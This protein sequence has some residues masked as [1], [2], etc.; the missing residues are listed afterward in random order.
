MAL[1]PDWRFE[2]EALTRKAALSPEL[3]AQDVESWADLGRRAYLM[4]DYRACLDLLEACVNISV[5]GSK[6]VLLCSILFGIKASKPLFQE[7]GH[8]EQVL[9]LNSKA[10]ALAVTEA[11]LNWLQEREKVA[12]DNLREF[13]SRIA[14]LPSGY[15]PPN[16]G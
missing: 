4:Q 13:D 3:T 6:D 10:K 11:Q 2:F 16:Q 15:K 12:E 14:K 7:R 8:L 9:S 1:N 5:W